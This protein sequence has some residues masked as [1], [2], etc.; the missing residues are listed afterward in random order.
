[1]Q[2]IDS[3]PITLRDALALVEH[4]RMQIDRLREA[5]EQIEQWAAHCVS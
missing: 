2:Y 3:M 5:L 1:M 4:Q